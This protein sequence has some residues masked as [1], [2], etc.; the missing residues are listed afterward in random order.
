MGSENADTCG[1]GRD[2]APEHCDIYRTDTQPTTPFS[3]MC[4]EDP[5][6]SVSR[7]SAPS[8]PRQ[9]KYISSLTLCL[10]LARFTFCAL[11]PNQQAKQS[12]FSA[13]GHDAIPGPSANLP[14]S[15]LH[16][17]FTR[18]LTLGL[19]FLCLLSFALGSGEA[20]RISSLA[21][22]FPGTACSLLG[23]SPAETLPYRGKK[24]SQKPVLIA[25]PLSFSVMV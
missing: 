9:K 21:S 15:P 17:A 11:A 7:H 5:A 25:P 13:T 12:G 19:D 22:S 20:D 4:A 1:R 8:T 16:A 2:N 10:K 18:L 23:V 6:C 24:K 3:L 14:P